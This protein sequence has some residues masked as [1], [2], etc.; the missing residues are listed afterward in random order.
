MVRPVLSEG[1]PVRRLLIIVALSSL[2]G[3]AGWKTIERGEWEVVWTK[4]NAKRPA[5]E[6][7]KMLQGYG[8]FGQEVITREKYDEE[9]AE[10]DRRRVEPLPNVRPAFLTDLDGIATLAVGELRSFR[11]DEKTDP[12]LTWMGNVIDVYLTEP[13]RVDGWKG[14][15][16]VDGREAMLHL[17]GLRP[18]KAR[19]QLVDGTKKTMIDVTVTAK[20]KK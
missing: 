17:V 7:V 14:D 10:G 11:I 18:G 15:A 2:S 6:K 19:L 4:D 12:T 20:E 9:I 1:I 16:A 8:G 3:C 13:K 5:E